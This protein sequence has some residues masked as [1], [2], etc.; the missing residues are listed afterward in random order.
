MV[1]SASPPTVKVFESSWR[2]STRARDRRRSLSAE[3]RL[4]PLLPM[5][6]EM[7]PEMVPET[8]SLDH[9]L[10]VRGAFEPG[11][12]LIDKSLSVVAREALDGAAGRP[13]G[14]AH[15]PASGARCTADSGAQAG[16]LSALLQGEKEDNVRDESVAV[17]GECLLTAAITSFTPTS[18]AIGFGTT[19]TSQTN[20]TT[21]AFLSSDARSPYA[22]S[23]QGNSAYA[24]SRNSDELMISC[25]L[26]PSIHNG[27]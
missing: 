17:H 5:E 15:G 10:V 27:F 24:V 4:L 13:R 12:S 1:I 26:R 19:P 20:P 2:S 16:G 9:D 23:H 25:K 22:A 14:L 21:T 6:P 18:K 11:A 8:S 7:L 3:R